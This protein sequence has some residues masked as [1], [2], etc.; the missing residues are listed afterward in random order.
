MEIGYAQFQY[1]KSTCRSQTIPRYLGR[2]AII[3]WDFNMFLLTIRKRHVTMRR[4]ELKC[5][6]EKPN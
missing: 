1:L 4:K 3:V 6:Q 5:L 2:N